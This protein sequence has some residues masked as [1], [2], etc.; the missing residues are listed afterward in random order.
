M[1]TTYK[2]L[3]KDDNVPYTSYIRLK[4]QPKEGGGEPPPS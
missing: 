1:A 4:R 3:T 2:R